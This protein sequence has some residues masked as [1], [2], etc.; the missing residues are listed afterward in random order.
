MLFIHELYKGKP[1]PHV[2]MT[3]IIGEQRSIYI[4]DHVII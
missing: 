2:C 1:K 3:L 4:V